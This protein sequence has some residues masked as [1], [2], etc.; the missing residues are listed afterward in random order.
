MNVENLIFENWNGNENAIC[1]IEKEIFPED[2]WSK[3]CVQESI[4]FPLFAGEVCKTQNGEIVGYYGMNIVAGEGYIA[5]I[6]VAKPFQ[7]KGAGNILMKRLLAVASEKNTFEITLEVRVSNEK[8][9]CLYEKFGFKIE[10]E[11]K[12]FYGDGETAY[13]MWYRK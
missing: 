3:A 5:N 6:A 1:E 13:I 2:A 4:A 11:R 9:I 10:A 8:A 12:G 7:G